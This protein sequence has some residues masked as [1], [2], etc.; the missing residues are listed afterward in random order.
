M[1]V[2]LYGQ[3][4]DMKAISKIADKHKLRVDRRQRAGDRRRRRR[5]QDRRAERRDCTSFIIQKNL[6]TF[7]DG[8][9]VVTNDAD[10]DAK[11]P[12]AAQPRLEQAQRPQLRLQQPPRRPARRRPQRQAEAHSRVERSAAASGR[13]AT[14]RAC[15]GATQLHAA[16]RAARLPPR[17]PPLRDRDEEPGAPRSAGRSSSSTNG[18]DA[19]MHYPIAIHQQE[20]YPWGKGARI[21]GPVP[22]AERNAAT[23]HLA[24]DVPGAD[25]RRKSTTSSPRSSSGTRRRSDDAVPRRRRRHGQAR[26]APCHGV[27]GQPAFELAGI[28][29]A[30]QRGSTTPR[31]RSSGDVRDE[32]R[33][34]GAGQRGRSR[35]SSASARR[36]TCGCRWS[37]SGSKR[38]EADRLR[39]AGRADQ[40]EGLAIK[41]ALD[42]RGRQGG[43]QPPAPLRRALPKVKEIIASGAIGRSTPSTAPPPAG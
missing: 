31:R 36:P 4:A 38:R 6:G 16:V 15:K 32:H 26:H 27:R 25:R 13:R 7:G 19:K 23:L 24:A 21:A 20:G 30:D 29:D 17:L 33:C 22:N 11:R 40:R 5:L 39:E 42:A 10:I 9:A 41:Q 28:C 14:R 34:R 8:G 3:C 12:Q 37:R 43:R 1:P 18:I 35:T 2:H